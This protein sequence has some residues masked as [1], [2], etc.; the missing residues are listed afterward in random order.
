MK[1]NPY[2]PLNP[3]P[4]KRLRIALPCQDR[5]DKIIAQALRWLAHNRVRQPSLQTLAQALDTSPFVLQKRFTRWA[6]ISPKDF[7]ALLNAKRARQLLQKGSS[8]LEASLETGL[9]SPSRLHDLFVRIEAMTPG[10]Y[11][12]QGE[13]LTLFFG[14]HNTPFGKAHMVA[15]SRGLCALGFH[16]ERATDARVAKNDFQRRWPKA[17]IQEDASKTR[18]YA[19]KIFPV[20]NIIAEGTG[21]GVEVKGSLFVPFP[22]SRPPRLGL[23]LQARWQRLFLKQGYDTFH[24]GDGSSSAPPLTEFTTESFSVSTGFTMT[25]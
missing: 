25:W 11:K 17:R 12:R 6:G 23:L 5:E 9:S 19:E 24:F 18:S 7:L 10:D 8:I 2:P 14:S 16:G 21:Q 15:S 22:V 13:H 1:D 20:P 4:L 3:S